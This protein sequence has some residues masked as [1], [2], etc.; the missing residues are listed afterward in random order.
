MQNSGFLKS[1]YKVSELLNGIEGEVVGDLCEFDVTLV[2]DDSGEVVRNSVFVCIK[3]ETRDGHDFVDE[4]VKR[5]ASLIVTERKLPVNVTQFLVS[6]TKSIY[7]ELLARF[8]GSVHE[9]LLK[10]GITGTNGKTT[11]AYLIKHSEDLLGRPFGL[12]STVSYYDGKLFIKASNTTPGMRQL[13]KL[14]KSMV[15]NGL[16]G[17]SIEVSSHALKQRRIAGFRFDFAVFTNLSRDHLDYHKTMEDY[18]FSK[19]LLFTDHLAGYAIVNNDDPFGRRLLRMLDGK[20]KIGYGIHDGDIKGRILDASI[21]GMMVEIDGYPFKTSLIGVHNLYNILAVYSYLRLRGYGSSEICEVI[22]RFGG[23]QG[24]L[25]RIDGDGFYVF[26]DYAHT[27]DALK[28]VLEELKKLTKGRLIVVFGCG[29]DRDKGKRP[30]MGKI[31]TTLA[32]FTII[33]SDNPRSE[34]PVDIIRDI[35]KGCVDKNYMVVVDRSEAIRTSVEM[36]KPGD[37]ILI[38][39]KGHED[40]QIFKDKTV[41][42][43]DREEVLK[44]IEMLGR[45][46]R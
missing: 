11:V 3:G 23:V 38:A 34:D 31:A 33:T 42:F 21:E 27:P 16:V 15:E 28:K 41:Y 18:F 44:A 35:I 14:M 29:G 6:D 19:A 40:Y 17:F 7:F 12:V 45:S 22:S 43:S 24:R 37:V 36:V 2:T 8:Y 39:G 4:A 1:P 13:F 26:I 25:E 9:K 20:N 46:N 32:D 5:G 30:E 10:V